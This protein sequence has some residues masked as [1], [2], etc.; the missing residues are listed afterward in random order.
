MGVQFAPKEFEDITKIKSIIIP[1]M[2]NDFLIMSPFQK[3]FLSK[4]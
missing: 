1:E 3:W 2:K 4:K